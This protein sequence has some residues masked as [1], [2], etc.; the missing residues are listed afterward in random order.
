M[1]EANLDG[2]SLSRADLINELA[3]SKA[4]I[5]LMLK[6]PCPYLCW[7]FG[8]FND[9][10]VKAAK[11]TGYKALF[12]TIHG[13]TRQG[14]DPFETCRI[15]G[16][17]NIGWFKIRVKIYTAPLLSILYVIRFVGEVCI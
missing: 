4:A 3:E 14:A 1:A 5:D 12:T 6:R 8:N 2:I 11:Q 13:V 15:A 7:P 16:Q 17:D 9:A 10:T